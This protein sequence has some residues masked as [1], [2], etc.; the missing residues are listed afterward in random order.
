VFTPATKSG[1]FDCTW[2]DDSGA[3]TAA[4]KATV[5][6]DDLGS[7]TDTV[8]VDVNNVAPTV[9]LSGLDQVN[10]GSTHTYSFT[11]TDPGADTFTVNEPAFPDC[12]TGG[13]YV[14]GSL[15]TDPSGGSFDCLFP[16]GPATTDVKIKVTDSDVASDTDSE[17]VVVVSVANVA[18]TAS[19]GNNGPVG[20]GSPAT[21]SFSGQF[22]PSAPDTS[23]GFRYE[24]NCD[25]SAF[26]ASPDYATADTSAS[27]Q[28][29]YPDN[30]TYTVR[31]RI[32]D[33]NN[34][35]TAYT[36]NVT[37]TNVAPTV[38]L[39][40]AGAAD[41]ADT[42]SYTYSWTD[43]GSADTFPIAGNSVDCGV[44]GTSSNEVFTPA[45]KSGSFDCT[46]SDDSGAGTA[47]VKA[48]V[49]DDD[50]GTDADTVN[51]T[52]SNVA[53]T[54]SLGNDGPVNEGSAAIV[55]F[56]AQ[57]DPSSDD[58]AAGFRYEYNCD[59]SFFAGAPD[60]ATADT[61]DSH[62]CTFNDNGTHTVRARIIDKDNGATAYTT[63]VVVNNVAPS[64]TLLGPA[65]ANE[66]DTKS[67]TYT[68]TDPSTADTF[69]TAGNSVDCGLN[70]TASNVV[71]TPATKSGSFDCTWSD[72]SGAGTAAVKATVGD[73]DL[74]TDTDTVNVDVNNVAP[75]VTIDGPSPVNE[76][77]THTYTFT[78]ADLGTDDTFTVDGG[79]PK[80]G[81]DGQYVTGSLTTTAS[82]GSFK[83]TFPDGPATTDVAIK[84]TDDDGGS[85]TDSEAVSVVSVANVAPTAIL[86][87]DGPVGEG[88]PATVSF[89]SQFD[90]SGPDTTASFRY[91]YNCDGSLFAG[92]PNYAT[93]DTSD[94]HPCTFND[95]G[96][97]TVRARIIDQNNGATAY[98]T[99]VTV[100]NVAPNVTLSG[101]AAANEGDTK[102]YSYT[103]T[104]PSTADTF[105]AADNSVDCGLNGTA[106]AVV[107]T[108]AT[109]SGSFDCTWSDDSGAGTAAVKATVGDDDAGTDTDTVNVTVGNV[110]P[111][112]PSLLSPADNAT[113][114]DNTPAFDWS[115]ST[116]PAGVN[117]TITYRIQVDNNCDFSS[118]ER[119]QT[120]S[121]SDFT[122]GASIADGTYCWRVKASDEDG[123]T[124]AYS[125]VRQ[126]TI[127]TG[128]PSVLSINRA[129]ANPT[130]DA[131]LDWTVKFSENVSSVNSSDFA[132][133]P[134]GGVSGASITGVSGSGDTYTVTA[135]TGTGSGTLGLNLVDD[136]SISDSAGNKLGGTGVGNGS[137]TG[138]VYTIDRTGPTVTI[139]HP[140]QASPTSASPIIFQA[141]FSESVGSTFGNSDVTIGGTSGGTK[142]ASVSEVA[143]NDGTTF[144]IE[145][146]G[147][148]TSGTVTVSVGANNAADTLGNG[149]SA[150]NTDSV[151]WVQP[152]S[153]NTPPVVTINSPTFGQLYA[154]PGTVNLS[155]TFTDPDVG[156]THICSIN[157]DDGMTTAPAVNETT[158]TCVQTHTYNTPGVYTIVVTITDN[159]GGAGSAEVLVVV[160]D[161]SAGFITGGG[162]INVDAGSY[163][164]NLALSGRANF[165]FNAQYKKGATVPT[166]QTEFQFQVGNLDFH[167]DNYTWL[168][169]SGYKAQFKGTGTVNG[170]TGYD[171]T[172]TAYDG[173]VAGTGNTGYD[174]FRIKITKN[175]NNVFDNR[176]GASMDMDSAN[177]QNIAGGSIVIHKA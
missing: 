93:A 140:G 23:A 113:T 95:N 131:S 11:V 104:D 28:C 22:D 69:P 144:K 59:G 26:A 72:D 1:S 87:N 71:F 31:A 163:Q 121:S 85:D 156:Q 76:G 92:A 125:S 108:P 124:S 88:S 103:W 83:C 12:G 117:D 55:S 4:V 64:V 46:W 158:K 168:V 127:D 9:T 119:D 99:D 68:W 62:Q 60:Y 155:A 137:F 94:S 138:Q 27:H 2:S 51:V 169:V 6:D 54:A 160:Y 105:P 20:E 106:S 150:S 96:T 139:T 133:V 112:T 61:S 153:G 107:F 82:G 5:G 126:L 84:V 154:K 134:G 32:I 118:P 34:G 128:T 145:V 176:N 8:N 49:G 101:P 97:Y 3:G 10:E 165:G 98:T 21:V 58:T 143:P 43:P 75:T 17:D 151:D 78:V 73:D 100:T 152:S 120:T 14:L 40:G 148:T 116:D 141:T 65:S 147:M 175:G 161:A 135:N 172:V 166:G 53:S 77:T 114:N 110:A 37:V 132:L 70:G 74:G 81:T 13:S 170:V 111:T 159:A 109:K 16:D 19:L 24:Y 56:S 123:G 102:S 25:G 42:K 39:L 45:T 130:G 146:T 149:N 136:D 63:D 142:T 91:E 115:N 164:A 66:G 174:R 15:A 18:P 52:V 38:T 167:S 157:W 122:P 171:F 80:C 162:W 50:L 35:A 7:D 67:Y 30:G 29:T 89:S 177:P 90:P 36:T 44:N 86:G 47:A 173:G 57:S 48:T 33:Q 129:E 79:Y 41:E